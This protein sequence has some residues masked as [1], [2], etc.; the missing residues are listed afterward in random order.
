MPWSGG[1]MLSADGPK[2]HPRLD[3]DGTYRSH[4][5][6]LPREV[7]EKTPALLL[8]PVNLA[9]F[10]VDVGDVT[11]LV[12]MANQLFEATERP[13]KVEQRTRRRCVRM[14]IHTCNC[15]LKLHPGMG[16]REIVERHLA[17]PHRCVAAAV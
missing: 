15:L 16:L 10:A 13:H 14:L 5:R 17:S 8:Y 7:F 9:R 1:N 6:H 2:C 12:K 11:L 3:P 4:Y